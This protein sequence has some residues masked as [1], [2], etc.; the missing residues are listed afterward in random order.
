MMLA[1][2]FQAMTPGTRL[3]DRIAD[4]LLTN[5][6]AGRFVPGNKLPTEA[7]LASQF[8]VSRTV[9]REAVAR[10][11]LQGLVS[12][13]QGSGIYV[14]EAGIPPLSFDAHYAVS[15]QAVVQMVEVRRA[16][17]AE[18][19]SLAAQRRTLADVRRVRQAVAAL[20]KAVKAGG[21]GVLED[22]AFHRSIADA[23]RNPFLLSTLQYLRRFLTG[24]TRVTRANEARC[25]DFARQVQ[26][27]HA[28]IVPTRTIGWPQSGAGQ[29]VSS[30]SC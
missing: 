8:S 13:R 1:N 29:V 9:I 19:A 5:I 15:K 10:L 11:K 27:E 24:A 20:N 6:R 18:V 4:A 28:L 14:R 21:D 25:D 30:G 26:D 2:A 12:S 3:A 22:V 16:L 23:A 17:E 7:T